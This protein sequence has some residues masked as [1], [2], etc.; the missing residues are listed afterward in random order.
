[1]DRYIEKRDMV[2]EPEK[3]AKEIIR[4]DDYMH[5]Y[6]AQSGEEEKTRWQYESS[7]SKYVKQ[8]D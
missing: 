1:M 2:Y 8:E 7:N 6:E 5:V 3:A 4:Q